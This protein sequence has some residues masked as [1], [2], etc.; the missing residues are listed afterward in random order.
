MNEEKKLEMIEIEESVD[1]LRELYVSVRRIPIRK[2]WVSESGAESGLYERQFEM[3]EGTEAVQVWLAA[4]SGVNGTTAK[5]QRLG[6]FVSVP[7]DESFTP[8]KVAHRFSHLGLPVR[9]EKG[10]A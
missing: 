10:T 2:A 5:L 3:P 8:E 4:S 6:Q 1:P 7:G 9:E